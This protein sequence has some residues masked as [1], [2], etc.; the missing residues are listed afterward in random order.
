MVGEIGYLG[1]V[2]NDKGNNDSMMEDRVKRGISAMIRIEVLIKETGLGIH[3]IDVHLLLYRALFVSCMI[4]NSQSWSNLSD[5]NISSLE[6]LQ[7][8]FLKKI[9]NA[10]QATANSFTFLEFGVL[11]LRYE[12]ERN[13]LMFLHHIIHLED[14]DPVKV[15][16]ESMKQFPDEANW[17]SGVKKL[18]SKYEI[19]LEDAEKRSKESYKDMVKKRVK[20]TAFKVLKLECQGKKKTES[21]IFN[22]LSP[23]G[24]LSQLYPNQAQTIFR[25]RSKTL[26]IKDHQHYKFDNNLCRRCGGDNETIHHI[27]NCQYDDKV[28]AS[29]IYQMEE[30]LTYDQKLQLILLSTRINDFIEEYK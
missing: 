7:C 27:V 26:A 3:T 21:L 1:D 16:W 2:I 6:K 29:I 14:N 22:S 5:K 10:P 24:Y 23:Q 28:D 19:S 17:W 11:P 25:G 9:V 18:L 4:F 30:E 8:K 13:Q 20:E 12:I 15:T